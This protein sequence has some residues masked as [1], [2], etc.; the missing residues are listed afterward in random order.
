[1]NEVDFSDVKEGDKIVYLTGGWHSFRVLATV[2]RV[3]PK[4]FKDDRGETFRKSDGKMVGNSYR[5]ARYATE[6]DIKEI[7]E[8]EHRNQIY[9]TL[10]SY[11]D[12]ESWSTEDLDNIYNVIKKY[13]QK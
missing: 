4:Q 7:R 3:T 1:M 13:E 12:W 10:R 11:S 8:R 2:T 9:R 6:E 5:N